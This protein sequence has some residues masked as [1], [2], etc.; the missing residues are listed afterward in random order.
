[1]S[2]RGWAMLS[3]LFFMTGPL[4]IKEREFLAGLSPQ[5]LFWL[6]VSGAIIFLLGLYYDVY[7]AGPPLKFAVQ[8]FAASLLFFG[9]VGK[10]NLPAILGVHGLDW[11]ALPLRI[12]WVV[13]VKNAFNL[14]GGLDGPA[15]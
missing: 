15:A 4:C 3:A 5:T 12:F 1:S 2:L 7:S 10:F 6:R 9:G 13:W 11:L 14:I 8:A